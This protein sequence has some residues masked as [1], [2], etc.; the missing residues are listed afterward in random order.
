MESGSCYF[1]LFFKNFFNVPFH[2]IADRFSEGPHE[3]LF[4]L[5]NDLYFMIVFVG[6]FFGLGAYHNRR[7]EM[8][9]ASE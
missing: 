1:G 3:L 5:I 7:K 4:V 2:P 8:K 6:L 9:C